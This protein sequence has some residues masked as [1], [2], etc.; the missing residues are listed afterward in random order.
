MAS[1]PRAQPQL[2]SD[3]VTADAGAADLGTRFTSERLQD[4]DLNQ[5]PHITL[6]GEIWRQDMG[7]EALQP[8]ALSCVHSTGQVSYVLKEP[9]GH[10]R[11]TPQG[12]PLPS[13]GRLDSRASLTSEASLRFERR[14]LQ[15]KEQV[16]EMR[17]T[18]LSGELEVMVFNKKLQP[19]SR[20]LG[21][22]PGG[23]RMAILRSDGSCEDSWD[24]DQ[25]RCISFGIASN[26]LPKPPPPDRTLSFRFHFQKYGSEDRF[27]CALF[28]DGTTC[29][30]AAAAFSQLCG[31][32]VTAASGEARS[33]AA[34]TRR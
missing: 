32:P 25:L 28:E 12:S 16:A 30:L 27:L 14:R 26:I 7:S 5:V 13:C 4:G 18:I 31:V 11:T 34:G 15:D 2:Q 3:L 33:V 9:A 23:R 24:V 21:L 8:D 17:N 29:R 22:N 1:L 6:D 10:L 19:E 20:R